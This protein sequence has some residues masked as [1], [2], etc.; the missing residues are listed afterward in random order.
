M[1]HIKY[2]THTQD[3]DFAGRTVGEVRT[4]YE[5]LFGIPGDA[6]PMVNGQAVNDFTVLNDTDKI[7]FVNSSD[8]G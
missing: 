5:N 2:R 6:T 3:A 8:K 4:S 1:I 7:E